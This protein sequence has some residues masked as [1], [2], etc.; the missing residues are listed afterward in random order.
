MADEVIFVFD[1]EHLMER[2]VIEYADLHVLHSE[3][4]KY[5]V[6]LRGLEELL[7]SQ[8]LSDAGVISTKAVKN[9]LIIVDEADSIIFA[10]PVKFNSVVGPYVCVCFTGTPDNS[11]KNGFEPKILERLGLKMFSVYGDRDVEI[12]LPLDDF[13]KD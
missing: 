13:V 12:K 2:D 6:G 9:R 4:V 5:C 7:N 10:D 3:Q 1:E 8:D 11:V